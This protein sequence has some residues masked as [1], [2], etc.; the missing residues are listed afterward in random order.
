MTM[1]R[2]VTDWVR[3]RLGGGDIRGEVLRL[4][5]PATAEQMLGMMVGIVDTFLVGH[6][7]ATSLAAV[8]LANQWIFLSGTFFGAVGTGSTALIARFIGAK[9]PDK[10]N[11]VL[12]QSV[13]LGIL[14]GIVA[15]IL[16]LSLARPAVTLLGARGEVVG[17]S[18]TYLRIVSVALIVAPLMYLGN[19]SL[20]GAGD[21]Q[22]PLRIMMVV[23][24]VNIAV[25]VT[26]INGLFGVPKMGVAGSALGA[27]S[28]QVTGGV[29]VTT[30]LLKGR[31]LI[32]LRLDGLRPD[33]DVV[34][35]IMRVGLPTGVENLLF[36][37]GNM[38]YVTVLASLGVEAYAA[39]QVAINAWSL[40]FMPGFGFAVA[41]TTLVGQALGAK[42]PKAAEQRGYTAY[43][44][45]AALMAVMGLM[46]VLFPAQI[47]GFFTN[48]AEVIM[49]G[50]MPLRVMGL[51]QP[52]LAAAMIFAGALRGAGDTRFPMI[53]TAGAIWL[54]RLPLA[55][56][57]GVTLGWGLVG[58]WTAMSLDMIVR[59]TFNF[60]RYRG[61][62]WKTIAV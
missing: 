14:I 23:N 59:G 48:D 51:V 30:V 45:G 62:H 35:R 31:G 5:L 7:G 42:E 2:K 13:L 22:T 38:A 55:Y 32:R 25:A 37:I 58:A 26:A 54:I 49:L 44:L 10:A 15:M 52:F 47:M 60:W 34:R 41:A 39:N 4:A 6:L 43:K 27:A 50:T 16:G 56:V 36:R 17:L 1:G 24:A 28:A 3:P 57:L 46:F 8:G 61:G 40:S 19:A 29:L 20:R 9:E 11:Q 21:T 33:W 18:S 53:I 12:C